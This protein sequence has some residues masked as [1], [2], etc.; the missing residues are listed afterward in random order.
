MD[1]G[2]SDSGDGRDKKPATLPSDLPKSLN[3]RKAVSTSFVP[4]TELYD[5]WQGESTVAGH[6]V[7]SSP[8][9]ALGRRATHIVRHCKASR[10]S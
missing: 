6:S 5:G 3:D 10:S 7:A 9:G 1:S 2:A 8:W 4:E